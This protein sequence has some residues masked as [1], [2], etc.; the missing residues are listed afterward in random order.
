MLSL[1]KIFNKQLHGIKLIQKPKLMLHV[2]CAPDLAWPI[3][4]LA[5][6]FEVFVYWYNP[7]IH[8]VNEYDKRYR[9]YNKLL[10]LEGWQ[11]QIVEDSYKPKE[12]FDVVKWYEKEEEWWYRCDLCFA[13]RLNQAAKIA[14]KY[15]IPYYSSTLLISPKK[16][17]NKLEKYG[18]KAGNVY[19]V[20]FLMFNFR[21]NEGV[22][23]G[24]EISKKLGIRRQNYC[25]CVYSLENKKKISNK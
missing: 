18:K 2:C 7:N 24:C 8:P 25:G 3:R 15:K 4:Y 17:L 23:K 14:S 5:D 1:K 11:F 22:R 6:Y 20:E 16:D 21:K 12:F 19:G 13:L 10:K 9:E